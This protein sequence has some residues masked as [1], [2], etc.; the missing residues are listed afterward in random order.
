[1]TL[2]DRVW[3][4]IEI[5]RARARVRACKH[6]ERPVTT[7]VSLGRRYFG[8]FCAEHEAR[9]KARRAAAQEPE[10]HPKYPAR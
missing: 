4:E 8:A 10:E 1:M 5:G 9:E 7:W 2:F 3:Q 6:C